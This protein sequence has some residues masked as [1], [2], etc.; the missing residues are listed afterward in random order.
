MIAITIDRENLRISA[1]GHAGYAEKG[2]DIVCAGVSALVQA[3][4]E[5]VRVFEESGWTEHSE[6]AMKDGDAEVSVAPLPAHRGAVIISFQTIVTGLLKLAG[7]CPEYI[8]VKMDEE[9]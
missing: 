2:K 7:E 6:I 5:C 4:A 3:W 1:K 8:S 9:G